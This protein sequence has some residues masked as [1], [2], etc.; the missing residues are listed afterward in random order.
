VS[1]LVT[2]TINGRQVTVPA[3]MTVAAALLSVG[4]TTFRRSV[5]GEPRGPF[6]GMGIC[7]ECRVRIDDRPHQRSCLT[8]CRH[9]MEIHTDD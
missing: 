6:C 3:D 9:G 7:F 1:D 4:Y 5:S 8:L 2:V